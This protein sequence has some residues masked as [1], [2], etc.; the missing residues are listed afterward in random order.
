MVGDII[1]GIMEWQ[2]VSLENLQWILSSPSFK[3]SSAAKYY[4][5]R[6]RQQLMVAMTADGKVR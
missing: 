5:I 4:V 6:K 1:V 3:Q 2:T